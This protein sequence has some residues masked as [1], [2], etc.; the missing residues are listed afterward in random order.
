M[1]IFIFEKF[2]LF[3]Q[4]VVSKQKL[5]WAKL[6][7]KEDFIIIQLTEFYSRYPQ[8]IFETLIPSVT[9]CGDGSFGK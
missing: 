1:I 7:S 5:N 6:N 2:A 4:L 3:F 9:V 8:F